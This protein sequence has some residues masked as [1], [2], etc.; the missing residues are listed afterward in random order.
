MQEIITKDE[1]NYLTYGYTPGLVDRLELAY[2]LFH[3]FR[4]DM[5]DLPSFSKKKVLF[6]FT[7]LEMLTTAYREV[8]FNF[9]VL[10]MPKYDEAQERYYSRT[11]DACCPVI[12]VTCPDPDMAGAVLEA[13]TC[14]AYN[15]T[16]PA[17][18]ETG[19]QNK[20]VRDEDSSEMATIVLESQTVLVPE[21]MMFDQYG[22][23]SFHSSFMEKPT[24]MAASVLEGKKN[25]TEKMIALSNKKYAKLIDG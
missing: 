2:S 18:I 22:N 8:D 7:K 14:E 6:S 5:E 19:L 20:Y 9:G 4:L 16:L 25:S 17:Y 11:F 15:T 1:N 24:M 23:S 12:P 13:L 3:D 10:P 21:I